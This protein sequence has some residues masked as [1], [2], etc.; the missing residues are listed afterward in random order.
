LAILGSVAV[1]MIESVE[2]LAYGNEH[3][4]FFFELLFTVFFTLEYLVRLYCSEKHKKLMH[5]VFFGLVDL[6]ATLPFYIQ[7]FLPGAQSLTI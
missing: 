4:F 5:L 6:V 1:T 7:L 2:S 3:L